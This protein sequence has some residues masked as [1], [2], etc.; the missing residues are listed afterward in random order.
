MDLRDRKF[1]GMASSKYDN[2]LLIM[3]VL[4]IPTEQLTCMNRMGIIA[5]VIVT[6][7]LSITAHHLSQ[8]ACGI[9]IR[10]FLHKNSQYLS[11]KYQS[12]SVDQSDNSCMGEVRTPL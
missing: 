6:N 7:I 9:T 5:R 10:T 1:T 3:H 8:K 11:K 2:Y 12:I 4:N